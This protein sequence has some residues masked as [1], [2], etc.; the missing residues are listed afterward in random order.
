MHQ[1]RKWTILS[2][3]KGS[4]FPNFACLIGIPI[5]LFSFNFY[6]FFSFELIVT[7]ASYSIPAVFIDQL[8][9]LDLLD[10]SKTD[11]EGSPCQLATVISCCTQCN[12]FSDWFNFSITF[13]Q[14]AKSFVH[15]ANCNSFHVGNI[16]NLDWGIKKYLFDYKFNS[17]QTTKFLF[18]PIKMIYDYQSFFHNRFNTFGNISVGNHF[19]QTLTILASCFKIVLAKLELHLPSLASG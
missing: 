8:L 9:F 14:N 5:F 7:R 10:V 3:N 6:A 19:F 1:W 4:K 15:F 2:I 13:C 16:L 11:S 18:I 17:T 12:L